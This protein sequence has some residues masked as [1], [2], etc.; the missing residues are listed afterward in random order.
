LADKKITQLTNITGANL[1]EADEFVVVDITADETKAIT[2][3]E[4]K[5]AFDTGTGFVRITGDTMTGDLSFGDNDKAIFGAG[6]DLSIYHDGSDSYIKEDGNGNLIIAADD[7]RVTNV[8]VSETMFAADTDGTVSL[9]HNGSAKLSTTST[10]IDVTGTVT[11]DGLTV[12][13]NA[14][15]INISNTG[16]NVG[17]IKM[18][19]SGGASTQYFNL[20]YDS[21]ASNTVGFDTGASGEYTFSVNTA[22]KMRITSTG[23]VG[24]GTSSPSVELSIAGT[25]PQLVLWEGADGA[26]SSKVQLGTG[27]AQGFINVHKGNGTRTVQ[28]NSDGDSYFN[29]GNVGIGTSSPRS[30]LDIDGGVD[31]H[32]RMQTNNTGTSS[33]DGLLLGLDGSTNALAYFWNYENAP[34]VIGTNNTER[35]R[36]DA[37]GN[38]LVGK[39][40]TAVNTQGI[41]L[42][43]N[44]RFYATSD[45]AESA[46]FNRKTSDGTI[47]DFRKDNTS[48]GSIATNAGALVL[49]GASTSQ[50]VQLQ[51]HDG[52]EDIEVD[53]DGFIKMETAGVERLRIDSSGNLLVGKTSD[54]NAVA[55]TTIS[56]SGIVKATRTDWSLLL[57]RLAGDGDI[58][59]F[60]KD[61]TTVG[62]I[63]ANGSYPYIGSHGTSGKGLKI[64]DALLPA[65]NAGAFNDADVNLGA[66]NVRWKDAYLSGGV[67]L[68]GTGS[69]N[70][71]D[72]YEEGTWNVTDS[73]GAGL[74]FTV[75]NN[76]YTKVGR[77]VVASAQVTWPTTSNTALAKLSV[78]FTSITAGSEVGGM[79]TEQNYDSSVALSACLNTT[80]QVFFRS[81]GVT[82]L[83]NNQL[84]GK[85]L[86]FTVVYH[87]S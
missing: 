62:S 20:T 72:S 85:K 86:R 3:S 74:T 60:Q 69:A 52:N 58:A 30:S 35:M 39:T 31:T 33:S 46:V 48:V 50:P 41:Q 8:A 57:N 56:N 67:Y 68:G 2:F 6:S 16:E 18:Y 65:T 28:I 53:P 32:I 24:I 21:G 36:I 61:G 77:L 47:A 43:S 79:V 34:V 51:T 76:S 66:S 22:E 37:S 10:G 64:T 84:A 54:N 26:S 45:G 63:G 59:L 5:T 80:T 25:D 75:S 73:S 23:N 14:P 13:A 71:L 55:G 17:G 29:G 12:E 15:Y 1:A 87:A 49:K 9:Y 81:N 19:D 38:L 11:A 82:A 83:R 44:G 40:T 7:F 78:P 4:L 70:K 42:G 27:T